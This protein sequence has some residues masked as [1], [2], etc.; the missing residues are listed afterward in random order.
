MNY[1]RNCPICNTELFYNRKDVR[2]SAISNN[3]KCS[4]CANRGK[5]NPF[6][7]KTHSDKHINKLK[8]DNPSTKNETRKKISDSLIGRKL[9]KNHKIEL[10]KSLKNW[11]LIN[12]NPMKGITHSNETKHKLREISLIYWNVYKNSDEYKKWQIKKSD[13][14]L[15]K[16]KVLDITHKNDI[17]QLENYSKRNNYHKYEL[18]HIYPIREG[19]RNNIPAELIGSIDNLRIISRNENRTK[20]NKITII[21]E[22][23]QKWQNEQ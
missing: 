11:H 15:Y 2:D 16:L 4:S 21:P 22:H 13:Y 8:N 20:S 19:F 17:K 9:S 10:S 6:F 5:N 3:R 18:D 12:D 7:E 14:E 1:S 23:I